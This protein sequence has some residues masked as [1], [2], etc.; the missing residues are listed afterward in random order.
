MDK[1]PAPD[2]HACSFLTAAFPA[3]VRGQTARPVLSTCER[4]PPLMLPST[5][6][7]FSRLILSSLPFFSCT[8]YRPASRS[9]PRMTPGCP[10]Y[11]A[12]LASP[13]TLM[14]VSAAS[15]NASGAGFAA[16]STTAA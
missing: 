2:P 11:C 9:K 8:M 10:L 4:K 14:R 5:S 3:R 1:D 15:G 13:T 6:S 7:M 16:S 12:A